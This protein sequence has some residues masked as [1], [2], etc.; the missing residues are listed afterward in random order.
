VEPPSTTSLL[1]FI[2]H[3]PAASFN[4]KKM[5]KKWWWRKKFKISKKSKRQETE[6]EEESDDEF[7]TNSNRKKQ[8]KKYPKLYITKYQKEK[9]SNDDD[10]V[11]EGS[12]K[13]KQTKKKKCLLKFELVAKDRVGC[14]TRN[15]SIKSIFKSM[16]HDIHYGRPTLQTITQLYT[17][18]NSLTHISS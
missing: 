8:P 16:P 12:L 5:W 7:S 2:C 17:L 3:L 14:F 6:F 13:Q 10:I 18:F 11:V 15:S 4:L 9:S 1:S